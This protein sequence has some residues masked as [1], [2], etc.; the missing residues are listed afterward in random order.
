MNLTDFGL[1]KATFAEAVPPNAA[2]LTYSSSLGGELEC[3]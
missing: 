2:A 1:A 3:N